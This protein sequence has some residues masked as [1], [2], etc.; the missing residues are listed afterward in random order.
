MRNRR[1]DAQTQLLTEALTTRTT[2]APLAPFFEVQGLTR[3]PGVS[4]AVSMGPYSSEATTQATKSA[5]DSLGWPELS[6]CYSL[7]VC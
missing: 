2:T 3:V 4:F 6:C 5:L 7:S 1:T